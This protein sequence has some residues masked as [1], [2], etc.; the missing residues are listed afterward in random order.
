LPGNHRPKFATRAIHEGEEPE[1]TTGTGDVVVPIHLSSTFAR[2]DVSK[3]TR[4]YEYSRTANPT[5]D[6]LERR[7]AVLEN[8]KHAL[9]FASGLAAE[10]T[11]LISLLKNGD[12]VVAFDDLYGG[13]R[14]L[15]IRDFSKFGVDFTFV[16]ARD[17]E[18]VARAIRK[19]TRLIWVETPTNP[20]MKLCDIE[21]ISKV[22]KK[23]GAIMVVD[24][25][26]M[27]PYFQNPLDLG[28]DVV[29]HSTTKYLSGHSDVIG[30][31][32]M[33]SDPA[34]YENLKFDQ[35][36][37]GAVP[38]PFDCFLVLRGIK[39]LALR[40]EKHASNAQ[41]LAEHL[42]SHRRVSMV[43]YPGLRSHPQYALA[44]RQMSGFGGMIAFRLR[45]DLR[46]A[47]KFLSRLRVIA[48]AE[49]L[50]GVESL[51]DHPATMTHASVPRAE[52]DRTGIT[53]DLVRFSVGIEDVDDLTRDL[54]QALGA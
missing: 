34:I 1:L 51:V 41:K 23:Y 29:V 3:P 52:R 18:K 45:G 53:D 22:A 7:L 19:N 47:R 17:P 31:A 11:L 38:S 25:T 30:G 24:N 4:G 12:H 39:T 44:K 26:F 40:M 21:Q 35:N 8:A 10:A 46:A 54:D 36:A 14:R 50:G 5:R 43:Y 33:L 42:E 48:V 15:F 16:D 13:T 2:R 28:A 37:V 9:A 20:L 32:I 6:S 27:S 49:S